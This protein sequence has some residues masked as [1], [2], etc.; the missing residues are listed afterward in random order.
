M[1]PRGEG[2]HALDI[3]GAIR[4]RVEMPAAGVAH[5]LQELHQEERG[6]EIVSAEPEVL[7]VAAKGLIVQVDV[8]QLAPIPAPAR[9]RGG[10]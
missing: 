10:S 8:E 4:V 7:V 2:L 1:Q 9:P 5:V 3:L 6:L